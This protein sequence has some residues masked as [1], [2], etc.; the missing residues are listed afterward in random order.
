MECKIPY[1]SWIVE[2]LTETQ[3]IAKNGNH[4]GRFRIRDG[5]RVGGEY[6]EIAFIPTEEQRADRMQA[7]KIRN[8]QMVVYRFLRD[9]D[10]YESEF[11]DLWI[12]LAGE[13]RKR[14]GK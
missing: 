4:E 9:R 10:R 13:I 14:R 2:R 5:R 6:F 12:A 8:A 1:A 11:D 7:I 3:V